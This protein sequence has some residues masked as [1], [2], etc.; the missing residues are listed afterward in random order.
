MNQ[1]NLA[2]LILYDR[3]IAFFEEIFTAVLKTAEQNYGL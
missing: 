2:T 1:I 3:S